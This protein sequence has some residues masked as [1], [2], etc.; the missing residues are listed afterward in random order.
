MSLPGEKLKVD[1]LEL[2][3]VVKGDGRAVLLLHGFPDSAYLWRQQIPSLVDG[4]KKVIAYDQRGFGDS[5]AP[6]GKKCYRLRN[7]R[8]DAIAV[9]NHLQ[10]E[11]ASVVGHDFGAVVGWLLAMDHPDRVDRLVAV[12]VGHPAAYARAGIKQ[13]LLAWY[14][15]FFQIPGGAEWLLS[16][17]DWKLFREL[18]RHHPETDHWIGDLSRPGRLT[19]GLNWYRANFRTLLRGEFPGVRVP[20]MGIWST[21]D[22][23]LAENQMA[24]SAKYVAGDWRYQRL[25]GVGH[26]IP[27]DA[28]GPLNELLL[29]YLA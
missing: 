14:A 16:A 19:A 17:R 27:L 7:A 11:K 12:S 20:V 24:G 9:L 1:D 26:W 4:G 13:K 3:V 5:D 2:N 10:V 28:P 29:D 8:D 25:S 18:V 23:A 15:L 22:I 6:R 21:G